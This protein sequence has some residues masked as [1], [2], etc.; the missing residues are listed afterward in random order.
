[1]ASDYTIGVRFIVN[2]IADYNKGSIEVLDFN[3]P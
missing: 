2:F 3:E 1:M